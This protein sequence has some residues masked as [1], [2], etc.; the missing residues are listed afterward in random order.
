MVTAKSSHQNQEQLL[1]GKE[2][3]HNLQI[4]GKWVWMETNMGNEKHADSLL[5]TFGMNENSTQ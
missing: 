1:L 3:P 2:N 5:M 4:T